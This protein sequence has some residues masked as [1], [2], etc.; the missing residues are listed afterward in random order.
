MAPKKTADG[1]DGDAPTGLTD[2]ELRFIKAM[3]DNMTQKPDADWACVASDLGFK[4]R[5]PAR[6][7]PGARCNARLPCLGLYSSVKARRRQH[8]GLSGHEVQR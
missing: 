4:G 8:G 5:S 7:M 2:S 1:A 3:F 6:R